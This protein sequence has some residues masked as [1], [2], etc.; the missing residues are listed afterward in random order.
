MLDQITAERGQPRANRCD[1]GPEPTG[2]HFLAWAIVRKIEVVRIQAGKPT[3]KACV[4]SFPGRLGEEW[5][6]VNWF[7]NL[8]DARKTITAWRYGYN[9]QRARSSLNSL[10]PAGFA[11]KASHAKVENVQGV[12]PFHTAA[13]VAG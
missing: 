7:E 10:A 12:S 6:Q 4:E 11:A 9:E 1:D 13:A 2:R 5:L 8:F 3:Q